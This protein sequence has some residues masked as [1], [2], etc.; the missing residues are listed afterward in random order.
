MPRKSGFL[1]KEGVD[2]SVPEGSEGQGFPG[3]LPVQVVPFSACL[4]YCL[5]PF[6]HA[7]WQMCEFSYIKTPANSSSEL[8]SNS[9]NLVTSSNK[10]PIPPLPNMVTEALFLSN[11][12][13]MKTLVFEWFFYCPEFLQC[14]QKQPF[15]P[16]VL[17]VPHS[18]RLL[19]SSTP[20]CLP[21]PW[22]ALSSVGPTVRVIAW[23]TVLLYH[24]MPFS[25]SGIW[26]WVSSLWKS[27]MPAA[28]L[29]S[30]LRHFVMIYMTQLESRMT[31][32]LW[33]GQFPEVK[34]R[35]TSEE[36]MQ[37]HS[38]PQPQEQSLPPIFVS[39]FEF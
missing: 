22:R 35:R 17:A 34:V 10:I 29:L 5:N 37:P 38:R 18:S 13:K 15:Y 9:H 26:M 25:R 21:H 7:F 32:Y 28:C 16:L 2:E 3:P 20:S 33:S 24:R 11:N 12:L 31:V 19:H 36:I 27:L 30:V 1:W 39:S 4:N 6:I 23:L 14:L 8:V